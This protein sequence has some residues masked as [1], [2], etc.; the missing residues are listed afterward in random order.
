MK[1]QLCFTSIPSGLFTVLFFSFLGVNAQ[2]YY[3][4]IPV[5]QTLSSWSVTDE[6]CYPKTSWW[7]ALTPNIFPYATGVKLAF[8]VITI[9]APAGSVATVPGSIIKVGDTLALPTGSANGGYEFYFSSGGSTVSLDLIAYG[10]PQTANEQY[11]CDLT[12]ALLTIQSCPRGL[13][14]EPAG[15]FCDVIAA[16]SVR[17]LANQNIIEI[18]PNPNNGIFSITKEITQLLHLSILDILGNKI[19]E[20]V[21]SSKRT[22][23]N[24][25]SCG[26]GIYFL[27]IC[28]EEEKLLGIQKIIIE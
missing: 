20:H 16:V 10:I 7:M 26:P 23:L 24:L 12:D 6:N 19:Q 28:N 14:I 2:Q 17:E 5:N 22:E 25:Y 15:S 18:S 11:S 27:Q 8:K 1:K 4:G 13:V 9:N 21:L 3:V